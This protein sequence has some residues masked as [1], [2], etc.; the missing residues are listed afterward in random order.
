MTFDELER[1]GEGNSYGLIYGS[2]WPSLGGLRKTMELRI[3]DVQ[4]PPKC[5]L[6]ALLFESACAV[7]E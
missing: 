6:W 1:T 5:K 7:S 3:F 2:T 4:A